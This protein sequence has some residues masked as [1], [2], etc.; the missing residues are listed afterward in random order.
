MHST[1]SITSILA[2]LVIPSNLSAAL[3]ILALLVFLIRLRKLAISLIILAIAWVF[4]WSLPA[5][6]LFTGFMLEQQYPQQSLNSYPQTQAIVV[7]GGNT[8]NSR[9][10]WFEPATEENANLRSDMAINL[11]KAKRAPIIINSGAAL[12]GGTSEAAIMA[13]QMQANNIP[14]ESIILEKQSHTTHEN[15]KF[16]AKILADKNINQFLLVTSA[17]HMPRA[18]ASFKKLGLNPIPAPTAPQIY[19]SQQLDLNLWLP[20]QRTLDASRTIIKEYSA[21]F[22]YWLRGWV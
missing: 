10:N 22:I 9:A 13:R 18:Y 2:N 8:A 15:A 6:T 16:T 1:T 20:D 4:I 14:K 3:L 12:D 7:L 19:R 21:L 17:L 5:F 11:Y